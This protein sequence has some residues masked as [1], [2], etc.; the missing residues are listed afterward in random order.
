M[1]NVVKTRRWALAYGVALTG[2]TIALGGCT[3]SATD[4]PITPTEPVRLELNGSIR[5]N[6]KT[7]RPECYAST[8]IPLGASAP[9]SQ[10]ANAI[11]AWGEPIVTLEAQESFYLI[12]TI[13]RDGDLFGFHRMTEGSQDIEAGE[14]I[15]LNAPQFTV[16][17]DYMESIKKIDD[18][19]LCI[20]AST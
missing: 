14:T 7:G 19:T 20:I 6:D 17:P 16:M 11:T 2:A 9:T 12:G 13:V 3:T 4:T 15:S 10:V 1:G 8:S 18:V 5:S